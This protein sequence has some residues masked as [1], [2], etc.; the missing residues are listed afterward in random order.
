MRT[1]GTTQAV[2]MALT[3]C[4]GL[5]LVVSNTST[6]SPTWIRP[7]AERSLSSDRLTARMPGSNRVFSAA[8]L[9]SSFNMLLRMGWSASMF[10][11]A[12]RSDAG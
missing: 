11:S 7:P 5:T 6:H 10:R 2:R 8:G 3:P 1:C 4:L 12:M 9:A